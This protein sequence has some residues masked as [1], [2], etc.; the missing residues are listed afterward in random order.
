MIYVNERPNWSADLAEREAECDGEP[1]GFDSLAVAATEYVA[2]EV[3]VEP[4]W[5]SLL[6]GVLAFVLAF[7]AVLAAYVLL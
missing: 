2:S 4:F 6:C 1:F 5:Q 3:R 7:M